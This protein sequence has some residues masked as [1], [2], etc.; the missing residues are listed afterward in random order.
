MSLHEF[1]DISRDFL[2]I[3]ISVEHFGAGAQ[4]ENICELIVLSMYG[5]HEQA[6]FTTEN[7][8]IMYYCIRHYFRGEFFINVGY[9]FGIPTSG[10]V[11]KPF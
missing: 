8:I 10:P 3:L 1:N 7:V 2:G 11:A 9:G 5:W 6:L 4:K